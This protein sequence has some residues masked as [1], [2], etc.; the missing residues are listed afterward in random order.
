MEVQPQYLW[1]IMKHIYLKLSRGSLL[2]LDPNLVG[3][4]NQVQAKT[5]GIESIGRSINSCYQ[6]AWL[7][8]QASTNKSLTYLWICEAHAFLQ[9]TCRLGY[10]AVCIISEWVAGCV[11]LSIYS[12]AACGDQLLLPS[13]LPSTC[14][15]RDSVLKV[16]LHA[17]GW[18]NQ[19]ATSV[20]AIKVAVLL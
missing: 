3:L 4:L 18:C 10:V 13:L 9:R 14:L 17:K 15:K 8:R 5:N 2:P 1:Q 19:V 6:L 16:C 11:I 12:P 20:A 7:V